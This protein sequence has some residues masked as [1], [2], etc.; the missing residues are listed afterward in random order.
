[1]S[2]RPS[3]DRSSPAQVHGGGSFASA[4]VLAAFSSHGDR[5]ESRAVPR[6]GFCP[7]WGGDETAEVAAATPELA[8]RPARCFRVDQ[9]R[10]R[11]RPPCAQVLRVVVYDERPGGMLGRAER[12]PVCYEALPLASLRTGVRC[13]QLRD[14]RGARLH[15]ASLLL[16]IEKCAPCRD[17]SAAKP[18]T[19]RARRTPSGVLGNSAEN[20]AENPQRPKREWSSRLVPMLGRRRSTSGPAGAACGGASTQP[21]PSGVGPG[22]ELSRSSK[23][24]NLRTSGS[25]RFSLPA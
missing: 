14:M 7:D 21:E 8:V 5:W 24:A 25:R 22:G 19:G 9:V 3:I 17:P 15:F 11:H 10:M 1:M 6:N 23:F 12:V 4:S 20:A 16:R 2:V 13:L 18:P